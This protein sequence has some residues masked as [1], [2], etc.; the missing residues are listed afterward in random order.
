M[1]KIG[2][3]CLLKEYLLSFFMRKVKQANSMY[4]IK[5][6]ITEQ[7]FFLLFIKNEIEP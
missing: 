3:K 6:F 5:I 4:F 2:I 7:D 1:S